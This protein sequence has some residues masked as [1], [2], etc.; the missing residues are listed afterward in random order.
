MSRKRKEMPL[1]Q[2]LTITDVAAE[3]NALARIDTERGQMV[4]FVPYAAPGDVDDIK[5]DRK[6]RT[7][8]QGHI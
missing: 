4:V 5:V 2:G 6:K 8:C 1:L 3:G 7:F